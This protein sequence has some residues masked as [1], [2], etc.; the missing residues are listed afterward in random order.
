MGITDLAISTDA[1]IGIVI[2]V[3][4]LL[5]LIV[6]AIY[7]Y[8]IVTEF[9]NKQL[10]ET[11][12]TVSKST[13]QTFVIISIIGAIIVVL[14]ML[15]NAARWFYNV[16]LDT[17][18]QYVAGK[19]Q[20]AKTAAAEKKKY[21]GEK[22]DAAKT[23]ISETIDEKKLYLANKWQSYRTKKGLPLSNEMPGF[24]GMAPQSQA[25]VEDPDVNKSLSPNNPFKQPNPNVQ[26]GSQ[27]KEPLIPISP[28]S[29]PGPQNRPDPLK[30]PPGIQES[31]VALQNKNLAPPQ[32]PISA[33]IPPAQRQNPVEVKQYP[34]YNPEQS[35]LVCESKQP[36]DI[37]Q[38][39]QRI[40]R[41]ENGYMTTG[42]LPSTDPNNKTATFHATST[43]QP[44]LYNKK[45][46][47]GIFGNRPVLVED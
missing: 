45:S 6:S 10:V 28:Q 38:E 23:A 5:F 7:W 46:K 22:L 36:G 40:S 1:I 30:P 16:N 15:Y 3:L 43:V 44:L 24:P 35:I 2:S 21:L 14:Y 17:Q 37:N 18:K 20:A 12:L 41:T 47:T 32:N 4:L 34:K 29:S 19:W 11:A 25:N 9:N 13:A 27:R 33:A 8:Q 39:I 31:S 26:V 42:I